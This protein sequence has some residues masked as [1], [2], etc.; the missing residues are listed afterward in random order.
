METANARTCSLRYQSIDRVPGL[1]SVVG[2]LG[3]IPRGHVSLTFQQ[4]QTSASYSQPFPGRQSGC[5]S[6]GSRI[7]V[8]PTRVV[9]VIRDMVHLAHVVRRSSMLGAKV[10]VAKYTQLE[11][12]LGDQVA[13]FL[14][15]AFAHS[16]ADEAGGC[17]FRS[18]G[19]G[20]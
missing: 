13:V 3:G 19:R 2:L 7:G 14:R 15:V 10:F 1:G 11:G 5:P 20:S 4:P 6:I 16:L 18:G 9:A 8:F 17:H 12:A